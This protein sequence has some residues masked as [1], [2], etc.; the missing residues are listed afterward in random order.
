MDFV[1]SPTYSKIN[2][3]SGLELGETEE[4]ATERGKWQLIRGGDGQVLGNL[5]VRERMR[6]RKF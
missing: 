2:F 3:S 6:E 4:G 5:R 1:S